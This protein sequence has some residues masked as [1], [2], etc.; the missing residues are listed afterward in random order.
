PHHA[1]CIR[2][3]QHEDVAATQE[4]R[5]QLK[6]HYEIQNAVRCSVTAVWVTEPVREDS[7]FRNPVQDP[8]GPDNGSIHS[9]G[10][11]QHTNNHYESPERQAQGPGADE[12]HGQSADRVVEEVGPYRVGNDHNREKCDA[13][14]E[15]QAISE[16][17]ESGFLQVLKFRMLDFAV[18]LR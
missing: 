11:H 5:E 7:I 12:V 18:D 1:E 3:A 9:P 16:D 15:D 17:N 8:V 6:S 4:D 13:G 10:Q 14:C 2:L